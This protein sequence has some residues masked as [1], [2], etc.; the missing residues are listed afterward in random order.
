MILQW[1]HQCIEQALPIL[2]ELFAR[3]DAE[4]PLPE[5][6]FTWGAQSTNSAEQPEPAPSSPVTTR[7]PGADTAPAF[8]SESDAGALS[9][10][11]AAE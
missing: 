1:D 6:F 8:A 3:E 5:N 11:E 10:D 9:F 4:H 2:W 7:S